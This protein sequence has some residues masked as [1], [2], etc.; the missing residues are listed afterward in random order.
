MDDLTTQVVTDDHQAHEKLRTL[1]TFVGERVVTDNGSV[2][3]VAR[4]LD[5]SWPQTDAGDRPIVTVGGS[6]SALPDVVAHVAE[7]LTQEVLYDALYQ[8]YT[9]LRQSRG[10]SALNS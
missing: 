1:L 2:L 4:N 6:A 7:P 9:R 3:V 8:C 10:L 5:G